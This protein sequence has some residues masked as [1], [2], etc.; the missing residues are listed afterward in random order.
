[1][2]IINILEAKAKYIRELPLSSPQKA[3]LYQI[4]YRLL[5]FDSSI[6]TVLHGST[7]ITPRGNTI[8]FG[9]GVGCM[10]KT[11]TSLI[12][13]LASG[14][15]V[16]DELSLYNE[17][18]GSV[19]GNKELPVLIRNTIEPYI[20]KY[21]SM[22]KWNDEEEVHVLPEDLGMEVVSGKL[23]AIICPHFSTENKLVEEKN[24]SLKATKVSIS[25]NAHRLK[26]IESSL[27][28]AN[29]VTVTNER[30][31]IAE[32]TT[33]YRIPEGLMKLPYYDAYLINCL[34]IVNLLDKEGL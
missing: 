2:N 18:T 27:D 6:Y 22:I 34:D 3:Y 11:T 17:A 5:G 12:V 21:A 25:A 24:F 13:G 7:V 14:K 9:D 10:G 15:Y 8:L 30:T 31:E 20:G 26:L 16:C 4:L 23:A 1:M 19:Y 32:W 33:G 28:R 29:G